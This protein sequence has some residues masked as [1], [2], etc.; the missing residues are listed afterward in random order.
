MGAIQGFPKWERKVRMFLCLFGLVLS[1][2]ALHVEVSRERNPDYR[3]LCDLG[4]SVSCSRVFTS[5]WGRGFGLVQYFVAKDSPLNQP[6]SV[7]GIIFYTLQMGLG[8][9]VSKKAAAFL[10]FSSWVSVA[11]SLYLASI[12]A[13]VLGDF[14]MVCVSTYIVN[15]A[16]LYTNLK[17]RRAVQEI[18]EKAR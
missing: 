18:K 17:R 10:V 13:F 1:V 3:A 16:L 9:S 8:L 5:R 4:E 15:F 7:L 6:N 12:L 2:Y 11:G 14:C